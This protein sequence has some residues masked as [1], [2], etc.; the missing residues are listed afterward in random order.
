ML[1]F[2]WWSVVT[3]QCQL[4]RMTSSCDGYWDLSIWWI[5]DVAPKLLYDFREV[6]ID[7][8]TTQKFQEA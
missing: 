3:G 7:F 2:A 4:L 6:L 5:L 1:W 8:G